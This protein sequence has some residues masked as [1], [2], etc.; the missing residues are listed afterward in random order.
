MYD[1]NDFYNHIYSERAL[2]FCSTGLYFL[3]NCFKLG[4]YYLTHFHLY[5]FIVPLLFIISIIVKFITIMQMHIVC[6]KHKRRS[7]R[8]SIVVFHQQLVVLLNHKQN[9]ILF[10]LLL[11]FHCIFS[12]I[13]KM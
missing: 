4:H 12:S 8:L 9:K 2:G 5:Y 6:F 10:V 3:L 1:A 13:S 7:N 11:E